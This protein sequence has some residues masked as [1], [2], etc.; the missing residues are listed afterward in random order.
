MFMLKKKFLLVT[1]ILPLLVLSAIYIFVR[2]V[3]VDEYNSISNKLVNPT[4]LDFVPEKCYFQDALTYKYYKNTL[5][6]ENV[7]ANIGYVNNKFGLYVYSTENFIKKADEL[8]NSNG[9]DWGYVLIPYNVKDY[10]AG[11]WRKVF[12]L[13]NK[14]HLIP[15][16][17]LWDVDFDDYKGQTEKAAKFL[18]KFPWPIDKKYI[19]AYNEMNDSRFWKEGVDPAGYAQVLDYT[20]AVFKS[21]D[22]NFFMLNGAFNS[23]APTF[24]GYMDVETYML[25]MNE[26]VPGIFSKLDGF[27]SHSYPEP[28]YLGKP[29][30]TGRGSIKTYEWELALLKSKFAVSNLPVF[31]TETGWPHAEGNSYNYAFYDANTA[32][33][34]I[35]YAFENV[36]LKDDRVVAVT[37]FTIYYDP[38]FDH[39]SWVKKDGSVYPQFDNIKKMP[40]VAGKPPVLAYVDK[41]IILCP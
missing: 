38:P 1:I 33:D 22:K 14:K 16:I 31:I 35:T 2:K 5:A 26:A 18:N 29:S 6:S 17:Q 10:D 8:V 32:A 20:I 12:D 37:P 9:G 23:T 28:N 24:N 19:S 13:L 11:K 36:W 15:I 3:N 27:A 25:K 7:Q 34:Y 21:Y 40:K 39:F 41:D 30:D 4:D